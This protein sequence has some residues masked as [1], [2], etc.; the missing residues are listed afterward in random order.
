M[1]VGATLATSAL[2]LAQPG[3]GLFSGT[4]VKE[5]YREA[6]GELARRVHP[7]DLVVIHP[8]YLRPLYDYYMGRLNSDP[9]PQPVTFGN[10]KQGAE[11]FGQREWDT[12]RQE[13]FRGFTRSFLLIAPEHARTVDIPKPDDEY[14]LV[15]LYF[16][17]SADQQ[18][19]P[20]GIWRFNG[21]HLLC[22]ESPEA[23]YTGA[24]QRPTTSSDALFGGNIRLLGYTLK[25]TTPQGPGV[26][27][28]GGNLPITLFYA[29]NEQPTESYSIFLHLCRECSGPPDAS[30]DGPPLAGYLPTNVWKPGHPARDDRAIPLPRDLPP[31]RYQLLLGIYPPGAASPDERLRVTGSNTVENNR[32]LLGTVEIVAP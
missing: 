23:Y 31:G 14:G 10:F 15:G 32:V 20:C 17:F 28:A 4:A 5:Q 18:K 30:D 22:Q 9:A 8:S 1:L 6:I 7:D 16:Q 11:Q 25:A 19:W 13:K 12:Q 3:L 29:V 21:A 2:S 27:R 26:Y 24:E